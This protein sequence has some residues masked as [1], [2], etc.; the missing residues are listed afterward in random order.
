MTFNYNNNEV[1]SKTICTTLYLEEVGELIR[2]EFTDSSSKEVKSIELD[3]M[4][5]YPERFSRFELPQAFVDSLNVGDGTI[6]YYKGS[7][8][9]ST[10]RYKNNKQVVKRTER[11]T[12]ITFTEHG[13]K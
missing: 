9:L 12:T 4:S 5:I 1:D 11:K 2:L 13:I 3:D 10:E 8:L 7:K 6:K